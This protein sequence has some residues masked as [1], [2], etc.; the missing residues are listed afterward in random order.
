MLSILAV[1]VYVVS[2]LVAALALYYTVRDLSADLVLLG[3]CVL[4][5]LA[6]GAESAAVAMTDLQGAAVP[7]RIT[8]YGYLATGLVLPIGGGWL[9]LFE[10]TRWGSCAIA[11]SAI[12]V[13]VLQM[14]LP[15]IWEGGFA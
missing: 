8:L 13:I 5:V 2:G 3:A 9:G 4:L 12:T 7:D 15:Q 1:V 14:R 11:V 10:R 6:W